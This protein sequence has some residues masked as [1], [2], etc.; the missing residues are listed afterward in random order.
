MEIEFHGLYDKDI[1]FK[2]VFLA[3]KPSGRYAV[4][5]AIILLVVGASFILSIIALI[6]TAPENSVRI[7]RPIITSL[8]LGY[9]LLQ[10]YFTSRQIA[11]QL[12]NDSSTQKPQNGTIN[13]QGITYISPTAQSHIS[14]EDFARLRQMKGVVVL[15]TAGGRL[16]IFPHNFFNNEEDWEKFQS[17][18]K[19][20]IVEAK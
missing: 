7:I 6:T 18:V 16:S 3:N 5:R 4:I 1:F 9:F 11:T 17:W 20:K 15:L 19:Y 14:W 8:I 12:W 13:S 2:A 10:P